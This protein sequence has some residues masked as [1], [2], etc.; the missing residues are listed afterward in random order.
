MGLI[1]LLN[2]EL[3]LFNKNMG[4][5]NLYEEGYS[6]FIIKQNFIFIIL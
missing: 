3:H 4:Y 1:V 5:N 6:I 2:K